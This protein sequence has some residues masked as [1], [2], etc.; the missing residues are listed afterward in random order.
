M[1]R[2]EKSK[3]PP[4]LLSY[5]ILVVIIFDVLV[6]LSMEIFVVVVVEM[7]SRRLSFDTIFLIDS[8]VF[9][10]IVCFV[11]LDAHTVNAPL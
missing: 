4:I 2:L 7:L 10:S 1:T 3:S 11:L 5:Y 9:Q 6:A 8:N